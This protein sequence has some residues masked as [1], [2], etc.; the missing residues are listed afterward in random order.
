M[1]LLSDWLKENEEEP[2]GLEK[3]GNRWRDPVDGWVGLA[4]QFDFVGDRDDI[5]GTWRGENRRSKEQRIAVAFAKIF[6]PEPKL[7]YD[8]AR[9]RAYE[10]AW[11]IHRQMEAHAEAAAGKKEKLD[12]MLAEMA[13]IKQKYP[14][15]E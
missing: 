6:A 15:P 9:R 7:P 4:F 3:V 14:K 1:I 11:P 8:V 5:E 2:E 12:E 13:S 10:E